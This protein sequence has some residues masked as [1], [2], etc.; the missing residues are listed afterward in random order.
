[1]NPKNLL[2]KIS[3][4]IFQTISI[5]VI[6][7]FY[8]LASLNLQVHSFGGNFTNNISIWQT[9]E[10]D[11]FILDY[12]ILQTFQSRSRGIFL[13][14]PKNQDGIWTEY[15]IKKVAKSEKIEI[16]SPSLEEN[17]KNKTLAENFEEIKEW[18]E[19]RL[20]VGDTNTFLENGSY[21]YHIQ[22]E[23]PLSSSRQNLTVLQNWTD[24]VGWL[25]V[26][27]NGQ[28][29]C[30]NGQIKKIVIFKKLKL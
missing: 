13:T 3:L 12:Y 28:I 29:Y 22:L 14:L 26:R 21:L 20:R 17:M 6:S 25:E 9:T 8:I 1:M 30:N 27:K 10:N 5:L 4:K 16:L 2:Q 18:N 23:I 11:Q 24:Q 15:K 7:V 19:L